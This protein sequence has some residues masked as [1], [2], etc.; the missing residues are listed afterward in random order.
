MGRRTGII[1]VAEG[2]QSENGA[3]MALGSKWALFQG[4]GLVSFYIYEFG[5]YHMIGAEPPSRQQVYD[6]SMSRAQTEI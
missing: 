5:M 1:Y 3:S 2:R 6:I 4:A